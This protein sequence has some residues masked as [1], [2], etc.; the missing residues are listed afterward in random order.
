MRERASEQV[1]RSGVTSQQKASLYSLGR[2]VVE[3]VLFF[4]FS[5]SS[6]GC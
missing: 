5:E 6:T 1:G 4:M 2:Q 3:E